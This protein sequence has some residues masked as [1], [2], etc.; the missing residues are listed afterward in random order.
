MIF[1]CFA[2]PPSWW[3]SWCCHRIRCQMIVFCV[4]P[5]FRLFWKLYRKQRIVNN[6]FSC[7][8]ETITLATEKTTYF[9]L[10]S[11]AWI[12]RADP[13]NYVRLTICIIFWSIWV[14]IKIPIGYFGCVSFGNG[15]AI[16]SYPALASAFSFLF[17]CQ[18][19]FLLLLFAG[20]ILEGVRPDRP[21][22][23]VRI[24]LTRQTITLDF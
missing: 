5:F 19:G 20:A 21:D 13:V 11:V 22:D 8:E 2:L 7:A 16:A 15:L 9:L 18:R 14:L 12:I 17:H 23:K 24:R 6:R 3:W 1:S 4:M 10:P